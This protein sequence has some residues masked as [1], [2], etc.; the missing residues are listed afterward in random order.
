[1]RVGLA[2]KPGTSV[3]EVQHLLGDL[4]YVLVM[5][6]EPGFGG[7]SLIRSCIPKI[8]QIKV[9]HPN[10]LV[11]VDGGVTLENMP[12]L[13]AAGADVF[14]AGTLIFGSEDPQQT[15]Q[16]MKSFVKS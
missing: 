11:Q 16:T 13:K 9:L 4:D 8:S 2:I 14:V 6:V 3:A 15:I 7:Q 1:M 12:E 5:T 10:L